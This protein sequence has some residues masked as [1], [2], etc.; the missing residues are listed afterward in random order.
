MVASIDS[1]YRGQTAQAFVFAITAAEPL[2]LLTYSF[3]DEENLDAM[4]T[5]EVNPF[6]AKDISSRR[7]DMRGRLNGRCKGLLE[8][9]SGGTHEDN[10]ANQIR[11]PKVDFLHRTVRDFLLTKDGQNMLSE[12][13]S[14]GFEPQTLLC[15]AFLAQLKALDYHAL[16]GNSS[17]PKEILEGLTFYARGLELESGVPQ[18]TLLNEV[19]IVV[20]RHAN[21]FGLNKGECG[22]LEVL[23]HRELH[24]YIK[25]TLK[26]RPPLARMNKSAL[27]RSAL[28]L[29]TT[30]YSGPR[31]DLEIIDLLLEHGASPDMEWGE[32]VQVIYKH[33]SQ[34]ALIDRQ[35]LRPVEDTVPRVIESLL[36][37]GANPK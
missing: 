23:V 8:V 27:L 30:K 37:H 33:A 13:L 32:F 29:Q 4:A 3:L 9:V 36:R 12:N 14:P 11:L 16:K 15:K 18:I 35:S 25:E 24:L 28:D 6:I 1:I 31:Y 10:Y 7:D 2:S 20:S 26:R 22:F 19:S 34:D 5:A 21:C 17:V